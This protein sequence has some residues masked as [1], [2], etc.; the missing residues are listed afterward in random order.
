MKVKFIGVRDGLSRYETFELA[1]VPRKGEAV[2]VPNIGLR[3]VKD[4]T[5]WLTD[6]GECSV[7]VL[8]LEPETTTPIPD[9]DHVSNDG[10]PTCGSPDPFVVKG[11]CAA[12][13]H[14]PDDWHREQ[15]GKR[16]PAP[17]EVGA[18]TWRRRVSPVLGATPPPAPPPKPADARESSEPAPG[19]WPC[20]GRG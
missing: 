13:T 5:W 16:P 18:R 4:V 3:R 10:C 14:D 12:D 20:S 11:R 17:V 7:T 19:R 1:L 2:D 6:A 15:M 8:L 9:R